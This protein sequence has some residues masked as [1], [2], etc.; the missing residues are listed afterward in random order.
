MMGPLVDR[1]VGDQ[2]LV[3]GERL[4]QL[5]PP[6]RLR[7]EVPAT[8][9]NPAAWSSRRASIGEVSRHAPSALRP[10]RPRDRGRHRTRRRAGE[11]SGMPGELVERVPA[12]W[13]S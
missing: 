12:D 5:V 10:N 4:H 7:R 6:A 8:S 2:V 1:S 11:I 13:G 9:P 3:A